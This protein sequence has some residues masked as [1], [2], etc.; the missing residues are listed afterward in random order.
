MRARSSESKISTLYYV[1]YMLIIGIMST[2]EHSLN[3][4]DPAPNTGQVGIDHAGSADGASVASIDQP[5]QP[6]PESRRRVT[7]LLVCLLV[8]AALIVA[9]APA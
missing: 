1:H 7:R 8:P 2:N 3:R 5:V 9:V 6:A 4:G